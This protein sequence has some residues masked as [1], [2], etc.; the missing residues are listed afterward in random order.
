M[1]SSPDSVH[2]IR[3]CQGSEHST[4]RTHSY[5]YRL[6]SSWHWIKS[7]DVEELT[8]KASADRITVRG[9]GLDRLVE[10]LERGTLEVISEDPE[11]QAEAVQQP[12]WVSMI[13]VSRVEND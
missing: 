9:R 10:A 3:F 11:E 7:G 13:E 5:P 8:I 2:V 1:S 6:L 12:V 4:Q